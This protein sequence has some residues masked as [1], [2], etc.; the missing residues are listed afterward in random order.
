MLRNRKITHLLRV[1]ILC[2][3][4]KQGLYKTILRP[5]A[6]HGCESCLISK[7]TQKT[8]RRLERKMNRRIW[9]KEMEAGYV[10]RT[11]WQPS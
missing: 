7:N 5:I 4:V 8:L 6:L 11:N 9:G 3:K 2:R 10:R 1:K